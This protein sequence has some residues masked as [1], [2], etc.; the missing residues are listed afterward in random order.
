MPR[1]L[2]AL[3][4]VVV[5]FTVAGCGTLHAYEGE[6]R[7]AEET[8][9]IVQR[10][11]QRVFPVLPLFYYGESVKLHSVDGYVLNLENKARVLP[12]PHQLEVGVD[13]VGVVPMSGGEG[14][15]YTETLSLLAKAGRRYAILA[16]YKWK[17]WFVWVIDDETGEVV[18]GRRHP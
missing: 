17:E 12:G 1:S 5:L 10:S 3:L 15:V 16:A 13:F 11:H 2:A 6:R 14:T 9:L 8:A 7:P 18:G 4:T